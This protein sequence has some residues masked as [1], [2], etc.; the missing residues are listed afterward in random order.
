MSTSHAWF[1][2][3]LALAPLLAILLVAGSVRARL[4]R[5]TADVAG[6]RARSG[7]P[8]PARTGNSAPGLAQ[9]TPLA[10]RAADSAQTITFGVVLRHTDEAGFQASSRRPMTGTHPESSGALSPARSDLAANRYGPSQSAYDA[11]LNYLVRIGFTLSGSAESAPDYRSGGTPDQINRVFGAQ[12]GTYQFDGAIHFANSADPLLAGNWRRHPRLRRPEQLRPY[13]AERA[14]DPTPP[15]RGRSRERRHPRRTRRRPPPPARAPR[16]PWSLPRRL[17]RAGGPGRGPA[18]PRRAPARSLVSSSSPHSQRRLGAAVARVELPACA[19]QAT[20]S[21]CAQ[22]FMS[23]M[24]V[25]N[26]GANATATATGPLPTLHP[27]TGERGATI[28]TS[29]R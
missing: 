13:Y 1:R 6:Q 5:P 27:D 24:S 17:Q 21:P 20:S 23:P 12:I 7:R 15:R 16:T 22:G 14:P 4:P 26:V 28:G 11:V 9:A 10:L 8:G 29:R 2:T 19:G 3:L 25:V 18:C